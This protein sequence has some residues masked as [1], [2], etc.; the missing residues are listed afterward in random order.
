MKNRVRLERTENDASGTPV[1][2][3]KKS[4]QFAADWSSLG[5]QPH[6][7]KLAVSLRRPTRFQQND[8]SC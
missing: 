5:A 4:R 7:G 3:D 1:A 2:H 6:A 8:I